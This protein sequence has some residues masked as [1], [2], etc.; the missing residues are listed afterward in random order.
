VRKV[1]RAAEFWIWSDIV[2]KGVGIISLAAMV[3]LTMYVL[4]S[5]ARVLGL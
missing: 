4:V 1:L 3:V 5:G 2:L